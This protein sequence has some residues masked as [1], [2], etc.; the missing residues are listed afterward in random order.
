MAQVDERDAHALEEMQNK[1]MQSRTRMKV[2]RTA[3]S[4]LEYIHLSF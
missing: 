2:V 3:M 1:V 4:I